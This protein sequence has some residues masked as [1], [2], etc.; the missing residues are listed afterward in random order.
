MESK[1]KNNVLI[2]GI[3]ILLAIGV[4]VLGYI[5]GKKS[6]TP[7][8]KFVKVMSNYLKKNNPDD[9]YA[10][11]QTTGWRCVLWA[12]RRSGTCSKTL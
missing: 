12:M 2:I 9:S 10:M 11:F 1:K 8:A 6:I 4:G 5:Y 3:V 7:K